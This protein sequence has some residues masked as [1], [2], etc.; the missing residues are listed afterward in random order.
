MTSA[1][2]PDGAPGTGAPITG[3]DIHTVTFAGAK[4]RNQGYDTEEVDAFLERCAD[5]V[6][7]LHADLAA[8]RAEIAQL[9]D[10]MDRDSRSTEVEQAISVLTTAQQTADQTVADADD[11]SRRVMAEAQSTYED[12]RRNAA[13]LE[14]EAEEKARAVYDEALQRAVSISRENADYVELL[15]QNAA[16]AQQRLEQQTM[17]LRTLRDSTRTQMES[18]LEGLLDHLATEY[19]KADPAAAQAASPASTRSGAR[20]GRRRTAER[21]ALARGAAGRNG[22]RPSTEASTVT[23]GRSSSPAAPRATPTV[24]PQQRGP[25]DPYGR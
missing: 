24:L 20:R 19:G 22:S 21:A 4:G 18:F 23:A 9:R 1:I 17:Y 10:K 15:E 7:R 16:A 25:V 2:H 6:E 5:G 8:A 3:R 13:V 12:A 11:Y 14:Q